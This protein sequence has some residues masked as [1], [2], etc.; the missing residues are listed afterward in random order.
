[1]NNTKKA[2]RQIVAGLL[3]VLLILSIFPIGLVQAK[4]TECNCTPVDG[5]HDM[6]CPC[7]D[8]IVMLSASRAATPSLTAKFSN[9][10]KTTNLVSTGEVIAEGWEYDEGN[11]Y[12]YV[13]LSGLDATQKYTVD[14]ILDE[15]VYAAQ[16]PEDMTGYTVSFKQGTKLP[17]NGSSTGYLKDLSGTFTFTLSSASAIQ[18]PIQLYYDPA[19]WN[20]EASAKLCWKDGPLIKVVL[21]NSGGTSLSEVYLSDA[22]SGRIYDKN[23]KATSDVWSDPDKQPCAVVAQHRLA[24]LSTGK[25]G[26]GSVT[27]GSA[28][29]NV[30]VR[31]CSY[32]GPKYFENLKITYELPSCTINGTKYYME[33]YDMKIP[34]GYAHSENV[35]KI[36]K[37]ST[38][39]TIEYENLFTSDE[40]GSQR[41][42][43]FVYLKFPDALH[44]AL[45]SSKYTYFQF[46]GRGVYTTTSDAYVNNTP[47]SSNPK[48]NGRIFVDW[49][50]YTYVN[51]DLNNSPQL[52][53]SSA[54]SA[55]T[56]NYRRDDAV[57][58]L[59][60][61]GLKNASSSVDSGPLIIK[62]RFDIDNENKIGVTTV[63]LMSD[64]NKTPINVKYTLVDENGMLVTDSNGVSEFTISVTNQRNGTY[65]PVTTLNRGMLPTWQQGYYFK[66]VEYRLETIAAED[67][68]AYSDRPQSL[69]CAGYFGYILDDSAMQGVIARSTSQV[70][71]AISGNEMTNLARTFSTTLSDVK[72]A[73]G[74]LVDSYI[75][76][77]NKPSIPNEITGGDSFELNAFWLP[78]VDFYGMLPFLDTAYI[79]VLLPDGMAIDDNALQVTTYDWNARKINVS[80]T[81][82]DPIPQSGGEENL[83]IIKVDPSVLVGYTTENLNFITAKQGLGFSIKVLTS[84]FVKEQQLKWYQ[85]I[86]VAGDGYIF[87]ENH[88]AQ[89]YAT[90]DIYDLNFNGRT[91]DYISCFPE[92]YTTYTNVKAVDSSIE[93]SGALGIG[94]VMQT[95]GTVIMTESTDTILNTYSFT[96]NKGGQVTELNYF[97]KIPQELENMQGKGKILLSGMPSQSD[98]EFEFVFA[99]VA[100]TESAAASYTGWKTATE[101]G[102][103]FSNVTMVKIKLKS[104][105]VLEN[106]NVAKTVSLP[107]KFEGDYAACSGAEFSMNINGS[108][109]YYRAPFS[110]TIYLGTEEVKCKLTYKA[111]TNDGQA[112]VLTAA[113]GMAPT[114]EQGQRIVTVT[115]STDFIKTQNYSITQNSINTNNV[116]LITDNEITANA[117][118]MSSNDANSTFGIHVSLNGGTAVDLAEITEGDKVSLGSASGKPKFTFTLF[119]AD[120][121]TENTMERWVSFNIVSDGGVTIPVKVDIKRILAT[122]KNAKSTIEAGENYVLLGSTNTLATIA[123]DSAFTAQFI[124][125][126]TENYNSWTL[127]FGTAL[128][129]DTTIA[130]I[131]WTDAAKPEYAYYRASGGEKNLAYTSFTLMGK[132]SR[133]SAI[134]HGDAKLLFIVD[135]P[136]TNTAAYT[137]TVSLTYS[138]PQVG[139]ASSTVLTC[140]ASTTRDFSAAFN[141][142]AVTMGQ[143]FTATYSVGSANVDSRYAGRTVS[144][145]LK[146]TT[147]LPEDACLVVNGSRYYINTDEEFIVPVAAANVMKEG[148]LELCLESASMLKNSVGCVLNGELW[149]GATTKGE[150][151]FAGEKVS[152]SET[153][154]TLNAITYSALKVT[155]MSDRAIK[156]ED[157]ANSVTVKIS[158]KN[159][160]KGAKIVM[161]LQ[162]QIGQGYITTTTAISSVSGTGTF[163]S[164]VYTINYASA[165]ATGTETITLTFNKSGMPVGN[166]QLMFTMLDSSNNELLAVPYRFLVTE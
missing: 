63:N 108:Y 34:S 20:Q 86:F 128:P 149:V 40:N 46:S 65:K 166:Y 54:A 6:M 90:A 136:D 139:E 102:N 2:N 97:V 5:I 79:G 138:G 66:S 13:D 144:M 157:F 29:T 105:K 68:Y 72:E 158:T 19:L 151:P 21:K 70:F 91:D 48:Y 85:R 39:Y 99:D 101:L 109:T 30:E 32:R 24:N 150:Q 56:S 17:V 80:A 113:E 116:R 41:H 159:I 103:D 110:K 147:T 156:P 127:K 163:A 92:T 82:L 4:E 130:M 26:Y 94:G 62:Q 143:N 57:S 76:S 153:S 69:V 23:K 161:E 12:L 60:T 162:E 164:G 9:G 132:T 154:I 64:K 67:I 125:G 55:P 88:S 50:E 111:P 134:K 44:S 140:N 77:F 59:G 124:T 78:D 14:V 100:L 126:V 145:V 45:Q 95:E 107:L 160:P 7:Y 114:S 115:V 74:K 122:I 106:S 18:L 93:I 31:F 96:N 84:A 141:Q 152:G 135:L 148:T 11:Q 25:T 22:T 49:G 61:Y 131:D 73:S 117:A 119:N 53:V 129:A 155:S 146:P 118:T 37:T 98:S 28:T 52:V 75:S 165:K 51:L 35:P 15:A 71:D 3:L 83:W 89:A 133:L 112:I 33:V 104:G 38:T 8:E 27:A 1:M 81:V 47:W 43:C 42:L 142:S 16:I 58:F 36:T 121:L 120:A 123:A 87:S 137:T 10:T